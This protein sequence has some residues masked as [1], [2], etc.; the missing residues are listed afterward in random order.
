MHKERSLNLFGNLDLLGSA[1][2]C[3]HTLSPPPPPSR[4]GGGGGG[5]ENPRP[6]LE[7]LP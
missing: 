7:S 6:P 4:G 1:A 5:G 3:I 2:F